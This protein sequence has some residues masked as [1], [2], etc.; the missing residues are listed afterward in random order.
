M[1]RNYDYVLKVCLLGESAVGKT[2]LLRRYAD[3]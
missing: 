2:C 1:H 3:D